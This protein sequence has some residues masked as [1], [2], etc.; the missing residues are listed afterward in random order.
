MDFNIKG[1]FYGSADSA[2]EVVL[3]LV[4]TPIVLVSGYIPEVTCVYLGTM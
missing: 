3:A 2:R 1:S 4:G